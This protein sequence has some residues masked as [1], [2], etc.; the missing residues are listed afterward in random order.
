V[1]RKIN[2]GAETRR[3]WRRRAQGAAAGLVLH[4][5][6]AAPALA[7]DV[8]VTIKP[9]HSLVA[10]VMGETGTPKLL[11]GGTASPHT[12]AMKP[13]DAKALYAADVFVRVSERLEPF[14]AKVVRALP[15]TVSVVSLAETPGLELL[16]VRVGATFEGHDDQDHGH[17]DDKHEEAGGAVRDGHIWL[18][19]ENAKKIVAHVA[20]VLSR[21]AP[22]DAAILRANADAAIRRIDALAAEIARILEPAASRPFVVFHDAYQYFEK[23]FGLAAAGAITLGP[24]VQ[25]SARRLRAVRRKIAALGP[26]CVFAE[27]QFPTKLIA[28]VSEG[29]GARTGVLDPVGATLT[30][31]PDLYPQLLRNLAGTVAACLS[32]P[33]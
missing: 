7:L 18:D 24:E 23:R 26:V 32:E 19:P 4:A 25:P 13:S 6:L 27:P 22:A 29:T 21:H 20:E 3:T 28:A 31:G 15:P 10:A 2:S 8:V 11:V 1:E 33:R 17:A 12:Y 9:I 30:P 16:D 5:A 14:T